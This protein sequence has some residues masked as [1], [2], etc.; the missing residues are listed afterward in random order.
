MLDTDICSYI[1]KEKHDRVTA[2]F[3]K[4]HDEDVCISSITYAEILRGMKR[5]SLRSPYY[6][7]LK[8]FI[9][10]ITAEPWDWQVAHYF[11][12]ISD[13]LIKKGAPIGVMDTQIA[14]HA[15][16]L[17]CTLVTNNTKHFKRVPGL[18][19]ENWTK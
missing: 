7:L 2:E 11:A 3:M 19:L 8:Q 6:P 1:V 14:A 18:K 15:L 16:A 9:E 4:L 12:D 13:D 5:L 17:K 10:H